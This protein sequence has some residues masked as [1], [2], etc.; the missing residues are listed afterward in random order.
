VGRIIAYDADGNVVFESGNV[1]DDE[2]VDKPVGAPGYDRNLQ[3]F[4]DWI[5]DAQGAPAHQFWQAAPSEAFADGYRSLLLPAPVAPLEP[6]SLTVSYQLDTS[7]PPSR[8]TVKLRLR[9]IGLDIVDDLIDSGDLEASVREEVPT[10]TLHG[11]AVEWTADDP[12]ALRSLWP[13]DLT[14]R[15]DDS[16]DVLRARV[17]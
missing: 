1:S 16:G 12:D 10:F 2:V 7:N 11:A 6:H 4:R 17:S 15:G 5:Y 9:P 13:E 14:C 8:V 3:V